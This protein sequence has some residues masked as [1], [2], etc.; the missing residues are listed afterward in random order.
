[1]TSIHSGSRR[2]PLLLWTCRSS[3]SLPHSNAKEPAHEPDEFGALLRSY[4]LGARLTQEALAERAGLALLSIPGLEGGEHQPQRETLRRLTDALGLTGEQRDHLNALAA[5][6]SV[7]RG[8]PRRERSGDRP[9]LHLLAAD[10]RESE[11]SV[12]VQRQRPGLPV[13]LTSFIGR[14]RELADIAGLLDP[15]AG[16]S[17]VPP[18]LVTLTGTGGCGKTR[19]ALQVA[20]HVL[21]SYSDGV[22]FV[23]LAP[24]ADQALVPQTV[25]AALDASRHRGR[26]P[27]D[28]LTNTLRAR[29]SLLMLD[30]CEHVLDACAE[31]AD[32]LLRACP[33]LAILATSREALGITGEVS[34]RVPSLAVPDPRH[35]L[36]VESLIDYEGVRL[37]VDRV[38]AVRS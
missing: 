36:P 2:R 15:P 3:A 9:A 35:L 14:Q 21:N 7:S 12:A 5:R 16:S 10:R 38:L 24:L 18:R 25:L 31:L 37:F 33:R 34:R 19:L 4:R 32:A 20:A 26:S 28:T 23:D 27:L 29:H 13:Q 11:P 1:V 6:G 22:W 30:N 17:A 8:L